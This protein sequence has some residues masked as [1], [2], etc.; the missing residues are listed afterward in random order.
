MLATVPVTCGAAAARPPEPWDRPP[1]SVLAP[2]TSALVE[3]ALAGD[4]E[5]LGRLLILYEPTVYR[6]AYRLL[7][8]EADARDA[9]Q[10]A[11]LLVVRAARGDGAP[12]RD[13]DRFEPWLRQVVAN[14]ARGQLRRCP[15]APLIPLDPVTVAVPDPAALD[16][17]PE[18]E[19]RGVRAA[20][21]RALVALPARQRAALILR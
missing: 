11:F 20:V 8:R 21:L 12:L 18:V 3:A 7:R 6:L 2:S 17:A 4:D 1:V 5:A 13:V 14:A 19:R 9:V 10:D 15:P 16:P